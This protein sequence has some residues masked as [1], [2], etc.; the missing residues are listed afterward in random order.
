MSEPRRPPDVDS[1]DGS[2]S[3]NNLEEG[4]GVSAGPIVSATD[5]VRWL[6]YK[7]RNESQIP[8]NW[9]EEIE[10]E[11]DDAID[12]S[13]TPGAFR[14]EPGHGLVPAFEEDLDHPSCEGIQPLDPGALPSRAPALS[15]SLNEVF[16]VDAALVESNHESRSDGGSRHRKLV[17]A[18][19]YRPESWRTRL[20]FFASLALFGA[21][22]V[23][24]GLGLT[25]RASDTNS[26]ESPTLAPTVDAIRFKWIQQSNL[27]PS[28]LKALEEPDSAQAQAL[29]WVTA[30]GIEEA[31]GTE[32]N[33]TFEREKQRFALAS[34]FFALNGP[35]SLLSDTWLHL[36]GHECNWSGVACTNETVRALRLSGARLQGYVAP[37][38][39][40]LRSLTSLSIDHIAAVKGGIPTEIGH[41]QRLTSLHLQLN[42]LSGRIPSELGQ[43]QAL[44]DLDLSK[45]R[46][47]GTIPAELS[48]LSLHFFKLF[49]NALAGPVPSVSNMQTLR[50]LNLYRNLL[51]GTVPVDIAY[52]PNLE[53][54]HL[55]T[56]RLT[57]SIPTAIGRSPN[58]SYI[59]LRDNPLT[60]TVPPELGNL[61]TLV[62]L[63]LD[64]AALTGT[65]PI[66]LFGLP[67]LR[68][69]HLND[70]ELSGPIPPHVGN[71]TSGATLRLN[72]NRLTG[73]IPDISWSAL[74][75]LR[76]LLLSDNEL[77]GSVPS[78]FASLSRLK[79]LLLHHNRYLT[80]SIPP[81]LCQ[82][83]NRSIANLTID[84]NRLEFNKTSCPCFCAI[85]LF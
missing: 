22:V 71:L 85:D 44:V 69:I 4:R 14:A 16:I 8:L 41:N 33:V 26:P 46:L 56:N 20:A 10:C 34:L 45:N 23:G 77:S 11:I 60:G 30:N 54:V 59:A 6:K 27:F 51:V 83:V 53:S 18:E 75:D 32:S 7:N 84:C 62:T 12:F 15:S 49:D 5:D 40:L 73:R 65:V 19:L 13:I 1:P 67:K 39:G 21:L 48:S 57:G 52:L 28:T 35:S 38:I 63:R 31:D 50:I 72:G 61:S 70:N 80:G 42:G 64:A 76:E 55:A 58:L 43:L 81:E 2:A 74:S 68:D 25:L 37:E 17:R 29:T 3:Y 66:E 24:V 82:L 47:T 36:D 79:V 78:G 9:D